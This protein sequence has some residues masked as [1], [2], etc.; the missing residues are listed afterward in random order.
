MSEQHAA[1]Q[2]V[3][4]GGAL[5]TS[6]AKI[7]GIQGRGVGYGAVTPSVLVQRAQKSAQR[8]RQTGAQGR[9]RLDGLAGLG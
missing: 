9:E 6:T 1:E 2:I 5:L 8:A 3:H 4:F 7:G